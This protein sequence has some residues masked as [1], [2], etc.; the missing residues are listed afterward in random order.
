MDMFGSNLDWWVS[1]V[2]R[3]E[4]VLSKDTVRLLREAHS[5]T[6]LACRVRDSAASATLGEEEVPVKLSAYDVSV[7]AVWG[8]SDT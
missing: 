7:S 2:K 4:W 6:S 3:V 1:G 5:W 8:K